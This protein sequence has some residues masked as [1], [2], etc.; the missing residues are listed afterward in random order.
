MEK[1][2]Y[3]RGLSQSTMHLASVSMGQG[4]HRA[5]RWMKKIEWTA[6]VKP[7]TLWEYLNEHI[8]P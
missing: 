7:A 3:M 5:A 8:M 1:T 6:F 4:K 2:W